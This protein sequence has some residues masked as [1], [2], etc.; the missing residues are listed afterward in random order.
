[1]WNL[2]ACHALLSALFTLI[3][4]DSHQCPGSW[5][6]GRLIIKGKNTGTIIIPTHNSDLHI[7]KL[8]H[9]FISRHLEKFCLTNGITDPSI[10]KGYL[11]QD[12]GVVEHISTI[13]GIPDQAREMGL[14]VSLNFL[15]L[16]NAF[17]SVS[18]DLIAGMLNFVKVPMPLSTM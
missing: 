5:A 15:D 3:L 9:K 17:G 6:K 4:M 1:M 18:H 12:T 14:P 2:P 16:K 10:Q 7:G 8:I 11:H 13:N